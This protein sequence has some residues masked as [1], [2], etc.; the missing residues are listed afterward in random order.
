MVHRVTYE[1]FVGPIPEGLEIDHLCRNR[2]CCNP[3]HLEAV[4]RKE[5]VRRGL[6]CALK[7][8]KTH[9]SRGHVLNE[10]NLVIRAYRGRSYREC[11]ICELI[12]CHEHRARKRAKHLEKV[13]AA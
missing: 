6:A 8:K 3:V 10:K 5:N 1:T 2:L 9:C 7:P 11:R 13:H 12:R 4:T